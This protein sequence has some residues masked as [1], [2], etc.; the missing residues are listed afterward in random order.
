MPLFCSSISGIA[1]SIQGPL[2]FHTNF[3]IVSYTSVK[4]TMGILIWISLNL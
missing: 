4:N 2:W 3:K 1:L